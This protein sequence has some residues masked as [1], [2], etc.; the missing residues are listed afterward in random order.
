MSLGWL[1]Y[2]FDA[3]FCGGALALIDLHVHHPPWIV[4]HKK[5]ILVVVGVS[6]L[7]GPAYHAIEEVEAH[8][9]KQHDLEKDIYEKAEKNNSKTGYCAFLDKFP[10]GEYKGFAKEN[11][12]KISPT[13]CHLSQIPWKK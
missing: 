1:A 2:F 8:V 11:L 10:D 9:K 3:I 5:G 12:E 6:F 4:R 13:P 7:L